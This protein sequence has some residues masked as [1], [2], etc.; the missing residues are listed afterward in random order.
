M[1]NKLVFKLRD[2]TEKKWNI[3]NSLTNDLMELCESREVKVIKTIADDVNYSREVF[4]EAKNAEF[5]INCAF[6]V[7]HFLYAYNM[8]FELV[9][10]TE[11]DENLNDVINL[12][13]FKANKLLDKAENSIENLTK[14]G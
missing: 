1:K 13:L 14:I 10:R 12:P 9:E 6:D 4:V 8:Q 2:P 11:V 3:Y 5:M 7:S